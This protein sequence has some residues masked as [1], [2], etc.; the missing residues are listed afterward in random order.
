MPAFH[1]VA[2]LSELPPGERVGVKVGEVEIA[3]FNIEGKVYALENCCPHAGARLSDVGHPQPGKV[4][5]VLHGALFD[6]ETGEVLAPPAERAVK[7][8]PVAIDGDDILVEV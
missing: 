2:L 5:C 7:T 4:M 8:Y 6:V 3:L 1:K